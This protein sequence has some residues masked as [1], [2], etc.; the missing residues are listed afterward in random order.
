M[1]RWLEELIAIKR[2]R[3]FD[4]PELFAAYGE[5]GKEAGEAIREHLAHT[6][7]QL[8]RIVVDGVAQGEF[9]SEDPEATARA[10]LNATSRFHHPAHVAEWSKPHIDRDFRGVL[11]LI[12]KGLK[13]EPQGA[14][15]EREK[16]ASLTR[17]SFCL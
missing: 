16:L 15:A 10:V 4:D 14:E 8:R 12:L 11:S 9:T 2:R 17:Q 3:L 13:A 7:D 5:L 1:T 6:T